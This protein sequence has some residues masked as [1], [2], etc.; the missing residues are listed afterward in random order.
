[1]V[2]HFPPHSFPGHHKTNTNYPPMADNQGSLSGQN[3]MKYN[4]TDLE[5]LYNNT[6]EEMEYN[7]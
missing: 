3:E 1:M 6:N 2:R 4:V 7:N 5:M